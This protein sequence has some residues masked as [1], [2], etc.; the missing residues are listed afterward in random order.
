MVYVWNW[1]DICISRIGVFLGNLPLVRWHCCGGPCFSGAVVSLDVYLPLSAS[2]YFAINDQLTTPYWCRTPTFLLSIWQLRGVLCEA[3]S[4]ARGRV[5]NLLV[6]LLLGLAR[7]VTLGSKSP[8]NSSFS[9]HV[10]IMWDSGSV[11]SKALEIL[12]SLESWCWK[13]KIWQQ[14]V[15]ILLLAL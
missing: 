10:T 9:H 14:L 4:L 11:D 1:K 3:P 8:Q 15:Y 5:C 7:A 13:W 12:W 6:Q 2:G